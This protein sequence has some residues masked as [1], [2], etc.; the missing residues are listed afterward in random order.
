MMLIDCSKSLGNGFYKVKDGALNFIERLYNASEGKGNINLGIIGFSTI[1]ETKVF[2][3][4]PLTAENYYG[5]GGMREF[6]NKTLWETY[7]GTALYYSMDKAV[8]IIEGYYAGLSESDKKNFAKAIMITFTDGLD[9][10]SRNLDKDILTAD[11]YYE[12]AKNFDGKMI[13]NNVQL[14]S[15]LRGVRGV[16]IRTDAQKDKLVRV[17]NELSGHCDSSIEAFKMLDGISQLYEEYNR[18]AD[19]LI[20]QWQNLACWAPNSYAGPVAWTFRNVEK[21]KQLPPLPPKKKNK[22]FVGFNVGLGQAYVDDYYKHHHYPYQGVAFGGG[23]DVAFPIGKRINFGAY[24]SGGYEAAGDEPILE[25]GPLLLINFN[26]GGSIYLGGGYTDLFHDGDGYNLRFGY[27]F[28]NGLY[29]FGD[30]VRAQDDRTYGEKK[31]KIWFVNI[32]KSF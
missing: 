6:I 26:N 17:A 11:A 14:C 29:L 2:P 23:L 32:G 30:F 3:M 24:V 18:I 10:T 9:Q 27:K 28:K 21:P 15:I 12:Y 16:D 25:A 13:G 5:I 4:K 31:T 19:N 8:E 20:K 1:K 7:D 22:W